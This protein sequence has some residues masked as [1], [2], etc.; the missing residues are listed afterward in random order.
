MKSLNLIKISIFLAW[1]SSLFA[2]LNA[3][4]EPIQLEELV[5]VGENTDSGKVTSEYRH[6]DHEK[7]NWQNPSEILQLVPGIHISQHS[8]G[9]KAHQI[10]LRGFDAGHGHDLGGYLDGIPLN[11]PSHIHGEGYLDLH[12]LIP[13]SLDGIETHRGNYTARFGNFSNAG[14]MELTSKIWNDQNAFQVE[15]GSFG[16]QRALIQSENWYNLNLE[17]EHSDG[18][19]DPGKK[20]AVRFNL[21]DTIDTSDDSWRWALHGFATNY[22]A[23]DIVPSSLVQTGGVSRY[24]AIDNDSGGSTRLLMAG[25]ERHR[26]IGDIAEDSSAYLGYTKTEIFSNFT[27]YLNDPVRGDQTGQKDERIW[28]GFRLNR[29]QEREKFGKTLQLRY[30]GDFRMDHADQSIDRTENRV[31]YDTVNDY[32][33]SLYQPGLYGEASSELIKSWVF[34]IGLRADLLYFDVSGQQDEESLNLITNQVTV[35]QD[36]SRSADVLYYYLSPKA[37]LRWEIVAPQKNHTLTSLHW[38]AHAGRSRTSP[39]ASHVAQ[40]TVDDLPETDMVETNLSWAFLE[41]KMVLNSGVWMATK[42][43]EIVFDPES[44][45]S[46][47]QGSSTRHGVDLEARF[48]P[49]PDL[50]FFINYY[51]TKAEFDDTNAPVPGTPEKILGGGLTWKGSSISITASLRHVASRPLEQGQNARSSTLSNLTIQKNWSNWILKASAQN[52]FD[53]EWDDSAFY[54]ESRPTPTALASD[55]Y[56]YTPGAPF[57]FKL[58]LSHLF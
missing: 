37:G 16:H 42:N 14:T 12:F 35:N 31:S 9:A 41:G 56:H 49:R 46:T 50:Y 3:E 34:S 7:L 18:F 21:S 36:V 52:L 54:Y 8:G 2:N 47:T 27:Y 44:G 13:E 33:F 45:I 30:G 17:A 15:T 58:G 53:R 25:A 57:N 29:S 19:T 5:I 26:H 51:N 55:D 20:D 40:G 32:R 6:L 22:S 28:A 48:E 11:Q 1:I 24:G 38:S 23:A 10:F 39:Q 43:S 4:D